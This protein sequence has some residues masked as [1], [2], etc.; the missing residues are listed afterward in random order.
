MQD[1]PP[2]G[3]PLA[4]PESRDVAKVGQIAAVP[5][6]LDVVCRV[7]GMG[8]A[9]VARV[10]DDRWIA[11]AVDDRIGFG[12]E[13]GGELEIRTTICDEIRGHKHAVVID[14]VAE[15]TQFRD[16]HTPRMYGFQSYISVPIMRANGE[17][18]GTL[19]AIDPAPAKLTESAALQT[20]ELFA[21][22][23]A[24]QLEAEDRL[25]E[26]EALLFDATAAAELREQFIAVLG[27]DLRNPLAAVEG[28]MRLIEKTPINEKAQTI[29]GMMRTSTARMARLIDDV[30]DLARGRL[31]GGIPVATTE[32]S[33]DDVISGVVTEIR[34][35]HPNRQI[36]ARLTLD[37]PVICD[38]GRI[39]QLLS[40]LM[41]N[42]ITHGDPGAPVIVTAGHEDGRFTLEVANRGDP[43]PADKQARLFQP[44]T[45][46]ENGN[47]N[48]GLGL[49]LYISGEIARAHGGFLKLDSTGNETRFKLVIPSA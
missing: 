42:A 18:F 22:L 7:T 34:N 47:P 43:I 6:I 15:D 38:P 27:H 2:E 44:F 12:L 21:Q 8:F 26:S 49:G 19:C 24:A 29:L 35:I 48:K 14:H 28:G 45:R 33:L 39:A 16:H 36:E 40:N 9:A 37:R 5:A 20:F 17:F 13:P 30:L 31:G 3:R 25:R 11:C 46:G 10:T 32:A 1:T 23:I 4:D 41:A